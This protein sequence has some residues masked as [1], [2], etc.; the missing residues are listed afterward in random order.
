MNSSVEHQVSTDARN[1]FLPLTSSEQTF[2][3]WSMF[4]MMTSAAVASWSFLMGTTFSWWLPAG[5]AILVMSGGFML[6]AMFPTW[7]VVGPAVKYGIDTAAAV[8]AQ[9]GV[10]GGFFPVAFILFVL[11]GTAG[12][13]FP[14]FGGTFA[15]TLI[16]W[17]VIDEGS[18]GL[19]RLLAG[20]A[21]L[22]MAWLLVRGG[23]QRIRNNAVWVAISVVVLGIVMAVATI[24]QYGLSDI[25][26]AEPIDS[27]GDKQLDFA[28][29]IEYCFGASLTW[30]CW[31]SSMARV[32]KAFT[33][34]VRASIVGLGFMM[35][36]ASLA[37]L[38]ASLVT[39]EADPAVAIATAV[40]PW[41][42]VVV[43]VFM[44][45][46]NLATI[47]IT[48]FAAGITFKSIPKVGNWKWSSV[49]ALMT[50][51]TAPFVLVGGWWIDH[52]ATFFFIAALLPVQYIAIAI[53]DYYVLRR[54]TLDL[55]SIYSRDR[56]SKYWYWGGV[57]WVAIVVSLIGAVMYLQLLDPISYEPG[58]FFK[59]TTATIPT[60]A[61]SAILYY[62]LQRFIVIPLG[63][64]GYDRYQKRTKDSA[65]DLA[66]SEVA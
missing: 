45:L 57:N 23:A 7:A 37:T 10:L 15:A 60:F 50:L 13:L 42:S 47:V 62:V 38:F 34:A 17:G 46:A 54:R 32:G 59:Y 52:L 40:G 3:F 56:S 44:F 20:I 8:K 64:G 22:P 49:S 63:K 48:L 51:G 12:Y 65:A 21:M 2:G 27:S 16:Q 14:M 61:L 6:G 39:Q 43:V 24:S 30:Y 55:G 41:L 9:F 18:Y 26:A 36:P 11:F 25:F 53:V 33:P 35:V 19:V 1:E 29:S 28:W 4:A 66:A 58:L 31:L 5:T